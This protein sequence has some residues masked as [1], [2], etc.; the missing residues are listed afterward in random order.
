MGSLGP[1]IN[2]AYVSI[3]RMTL[4]FTFSPLTCFALR[5]LISIGKYWDESMP[6]LLDHLECTSFFQHLPALQCAALTWVDFDL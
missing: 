3:R 2:E 4:F 6:A 1:I 5:P